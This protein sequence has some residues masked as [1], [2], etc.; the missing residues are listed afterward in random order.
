MKYNIELRDK[1]GNLFVDKHGS[2][3]G[4]NAFS[5]D[6]PEESPELIQLICQ[7]TAEV[8]EAITPP[9][10]KINISVMDYSHI[11]NTYPVYHSYYHDEKR[12]I[13]HE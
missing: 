1:N 2:K 12:F 8:Y 3:I 9:K 5:F 13:T 11:S 10:T 4:H 7:R 6:D